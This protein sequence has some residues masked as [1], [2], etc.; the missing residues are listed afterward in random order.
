MKL[1]SNYTYVL[2][3]VRH[4]KCIVLNVDKVSFNLI[5]MLNKIDVS[6]GKLF[7]LLCTSLSNLKLKF[8]TFLAAS[9]KT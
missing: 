8:K 1:K 6:H 3:I 9:L 5:S 2:L 4:S 7:K